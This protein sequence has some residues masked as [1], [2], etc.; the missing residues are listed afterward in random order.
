MT[1]LLKFRAAI[2]MLLFA[3]V[4]II[5]EGCASTHAHKKKK[6]LK[7]GKEI[8]CPLKDC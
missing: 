5:A 1:T 3:S 8:P 4:M 7:P 6:K 2:I